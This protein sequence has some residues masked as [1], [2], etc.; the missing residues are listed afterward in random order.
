MWTI[1]KRRPLKSK[2]IITSNAHNWHHK[3]YLAHGSWSNNYYFTWSLSIFREKSWPPGPSLTAFLEFKGQGTYKIIYPVWDI[4][5]EKTCSFQNL[6]AYFHLNSSGASNGRIRQVS[7][8]GHSSRCI[9]EAW[10]TTVRPGVTSG[11]SVEF[12]AI[13]SKYRRMCL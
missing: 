9:S 13:L 4:A 1:V 5:F 2:L 8:V 11:R 10:W 12:I 3:R 6:I 7:G